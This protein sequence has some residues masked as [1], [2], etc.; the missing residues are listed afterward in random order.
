[1]FQLFLSNKKQFV[2]MYR[3]LWLGQ[4][5]GHGGIPQ[6]SIL[7]SMLFNMSYIKCI[8]DTQLD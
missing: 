7:G 6:G 5:T 4:I 8:N 1:M 2:Y 3:W